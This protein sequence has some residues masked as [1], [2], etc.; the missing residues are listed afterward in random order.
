[1]FYENTSIHRIVPNFSKHRI[2][3]ICLIVNIE[4]FRCIDLYRIS[5][6]ETYQ[7]SFRVFICASHPEISSFFRSES[8]LFIFIFVT[9]RHLYRMLTCIYSLLIEKGLRECQNVSVKIPCI[10]LCLSSEYFFIFRQGFPLFIPIFITWQHLYTMFTY[11]YSIVIEINPRECSKRMFKF[12][13]V[14]L[15]LSSKDLFIF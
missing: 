5:L 14:Y 12:P 1:M 6:V 11:N 7:L 10:C 8:P 9:W 4:W 2:D 15:C 3:S 13:C